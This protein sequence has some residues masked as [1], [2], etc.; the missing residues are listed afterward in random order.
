MDSPEETLEKIPPPKTL[1]LGHGKAVRIRYVGTTLERIIPL[2]VCEYS[3]LESGN[4]RA[5]IESEVWTVRLEREQSFEEGT[6]RIAR[7]GVNV[8]IW[9]G[10]EPW[11]YANALNLGVAEDRAL[12]G[13][14]PP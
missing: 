7:K 2:A 14:A 1:R 13:A 9:I 12:P 3:F 11:A 8:L 10:G 4:A 6:V 5:V